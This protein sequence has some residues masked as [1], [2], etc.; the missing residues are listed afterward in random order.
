V[1]ENPVHGSS[2]GLRNLRDVGDIPAKNNRWVPRGRLYRSDAPIVGDP[3]PQLRP[4]PPRTVV[5]LRSPGESRPG[6]H[7]LVSAGARVV[8]IPLF[9]QLEPGKLAAGDPR[10]PPDLPTIYRRLLRASAVNLVDV[11]RVIAEGPAPVLLH[12][13]A[14]K[15]RTGVAT[16]V[17]L[18]AVGVAP[19]AI[20]ADYLR[21]ATSLDG[22]LARLALGWSEHH[23]AARLRQLTVERPDLMHAPAAAIQAVLETLDAWPGTT[24]GW[25]LDHGLTEPELGRLIDRLTVPAAD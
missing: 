12:C 3:D 9:R 24:P 8:N 18:A 2:S 22:L 6:V 10:E 16:A 5:D 15:D 13:A 19:D 25:L 23:R 11:V 20:V 21:T 7:P 1:H 17:A 14:G 4:W